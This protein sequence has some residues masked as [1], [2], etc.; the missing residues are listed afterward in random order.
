[1]LLEVHNMNR[2]FGRAAQLG[3]SSQQEQNALAGSGGTVSKKLRVLAQKRRPAGCGKGFFQPWPP[4]D[5]E[6]RL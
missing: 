1:M 3:Q 2:C 5:P 6:R 4:V